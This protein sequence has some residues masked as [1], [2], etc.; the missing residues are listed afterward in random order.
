MSMNGIDI[1][2]W[3]D[4]IDLEKV[5][6]DFVIMKATEGVWM[7]DNCCDKFYRQ[8]KSMGRLLGVYHYADGGDYK[9][10]AD[11][12]LK[13]V[14]A[15]IG[16]AV[17]VLDWEGD[18]NKLFNTGKDKEWVKNWCDY[19]YKKSG[20]KPIVYT[21]K[22]FMPLIKGIGDY[23][24]WIAQYADTSTTGYQVKPWNEGAYDCIMRQ[25][26]ST[27]RLPG[28]LGNLDLNKFY[29]DK[30]KWKSLAKVANKNEPV[31]KEEPNKPKES[32]LEL[33]AK[34]M[35]GK[36]GVGDARKKALG[37]RYGDVQNVINHIASAKASVLAEEVK[38]GK[39]GVGELRK[40]VLGDRYDEVQKIVNAESGKN[41]ASTSATYYI[42][43]SGDTLSKIATRFGTSYQRL[44]KMNN[45]SNP[46]KIYTGQKIRVK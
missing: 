37:G 41:N 34:T 33:V 1:S 25:Y 23:E 16:E 20:V 35:Q 40:T 8:A 36:F 44:A 22:A 27:G 7:I 15:Y 46:N 12:F 31:K 42:V 3:Q 11:F 18:G 14:S 39:Y 5:P 43:K 28:Y 9:A 10:E 29:G 6:C 24:L 30:E 17:L 13:K 26:S 32:L 4:G 19:V 45:I 38:T 21:S 2:H